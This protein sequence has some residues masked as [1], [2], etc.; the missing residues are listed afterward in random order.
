[1]GEHK[2]KHFYEFERFRID[3]VKRLLLRDGEPQPLT[4]KAFD[5]LL[6]LLQHRGGILEKD[7]LMR[8]VW[9]DTVVE[10]NNLTRNISALRKALGDSPNE[11]Q[12]VVTIPGRGYRFVADVRELQDED[13][14]L[15]V[16]TYSR[17]RVVIDEEEDTS[18]PARLNQD[19]LQK[20]LLASGG[21]QSEASWRRLP[22]FLIVGAL[23]V[24]LTTALSYSWMS[25]KSKE[26]EAS[27]SVR[28][29]AVLPFK[30][31][32]SEADEEYLGWGMTDALITRL[33]SVR[34]IMVRP[35]NAVHKYTVIGQDALAAG[36]ELRVD[37]VL[38]GN[39]QRFGEQ[40]RVTVQLVSV[41]D[42]RPL[43]AEKFDAKFTDIFAVQDSISD[44]VARAL[45]LKL[46]G[47]EKQRLTK[48]YTEDIQAYQAYLKGRYFWNKRTEEGYKRAIEYFEQA[49]ERDPRYAQAYAGL[50][51]S[52]ALLGSM[53]NAVL[54]RSEAMPR[55]RVAAEKA[56]LI[57][58]TL[59]EAHASL[60]FVRMHYE[61][62]WPGAEREFKRAIE[63]NPSYAT[64]HH[65]Y[66]YYLVARG[67]TDESLAEIKRAQEIDP[68]SL[69]INTDV[70]EMYFF[71]RQYDRA[72]EQC[73]KTL[74]LD[75]EFNLAVR[76]LGW[77]YLQKGMHKEAIAEL[78]RS[79]SL[80]E[81]RRDST[82]LL[83]YAY[84]V[85]GKREE[86]KKV[87]AE[88]KEIA[89]RS[90][91]APFE[92]SLVYTGLNEKDQAFA[93]LEKAYDE[94]SGSLILLNVDPASDGLR[95]D[96]RFADLVRR[97]N[98]KH[99]THPIN[100]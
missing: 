85:A 56:L 16:E 79:V 3:P 88:L 45:T 1:M 10:E 52:Y 8:A 59:A 87:L 73:K 17:S 75:P 40:I 23:L 37:A 65:W 78:E 4:P 34:Q 80:S 54:P 41:R 48:H 89:K 81:G 100:N 92:L 11:H 98:A 33:S 30:V 99:E 25:S 91:V 5:I 57:D 47:E 60:A 90:Y 62:D 97:V 18:E 95:S 44:Q 58:E 38:D 22:V 82:A 67:R 94:R 6:V 83:G 28:S 64:A 31:V 77:T 74:E 76:H 69:I 96:P 29:M 27:S 72:I 49:L 9:P 84:A 20:P 2:N 50:A 7:E 24:G 32:G 26:A 39:I 55:A 51:D 15:I 12:Y 35:T 63:L 46:I 36:R 19:L 66:A 42:G 71:A 21:K 61:W 93:W 86:A 70:G 13:A 14:D 43:W 68:L 53:G